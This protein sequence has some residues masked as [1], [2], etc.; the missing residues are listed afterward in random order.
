[1]PGVDRDAP[2]R[3]DV[4]ALY[5]DLHPRLIAAARS[6]APS[7]HVDDVVQETWAAVVSGLDRFEGRSKISTWVFGILWRQSARK[8]RDRRIRHVPVGEA[9][10]DEDWSASRQIE[11]ESVWSDP[12]RLAE[13]RIEG[14]LALNLI[15][16]LPERYRAIVTMRDLRD[17]TAA[18]A[19]A[20][21]GLSGANQ[22]VLLHRARRRV[23]AQLIELGVGAGSQ[24]GAA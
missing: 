2:P 10:G 17:C 11:D 3:H 9:F 14:D 22:R 7:E 15:A 5:H 20:A 18:E 4:D 12:A 21:L 24:A 13:S 1:M 8:W 6:W 19:E 16:E 23:R